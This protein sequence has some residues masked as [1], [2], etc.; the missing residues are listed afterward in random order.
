[1]SFT[2]PAD[3]LHDEIVRNHSDLWLYIIDKYKNAPSSP[4]VGLGDL[5]VSPLIELS[6]WGFPITYVNFGVDGVEES[7]KAAEKFAGEFNRFYH[8]DFIKD[9]PKAAITLSIGIA[10]NLPER[11]MVKW[12]DL[13]LRRCHE[14]IFPVPIDRDWNRL[15]SS[16][17]DTLINKYR[18]GNYYLICLTKKYEPKKLGREMEERGKDTKANSKTKVLREE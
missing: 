7:K 3:E 16:R 1:M 18:S 8:I 4:I 10:E 2:S 13:L 6:N 15:L 17:Y 11:E 12:L 5:V 14:V 9:V